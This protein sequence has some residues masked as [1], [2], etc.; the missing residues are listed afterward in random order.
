MRRLGISLGS[1][2]LIAIITGTIVDCST[3]THLRSKEALQ[4]SGNNSNSSGTI[5]LRKKR[6]IRYE[7]LPLSIRKRLA[8]NLETISDYE[9]DLDDEESDSFQSI[10]RYNRGP[11]DADNDFD[12]HSVDKRAA[13]TNEEES[14]EQGVEEIGVNDPVPNKS[15]VKRDK[16]LQEDLRKKVNLELAKSQLERVE[17]KVEDEIRSLKKRSKSSGDTSKSESDSKKRQIITPNVSSHPRLLKIE[18]DTFEI[19]QESPKDT[20][21]SVDRLKKSEIDAVS[22]KSS[23]DLQKDVRRELPLS[24]TENELRNKDKNEPKEVEDQLQRRIEAVKEKV[25]REIEENARIKE[26]EAN[27]AKYDELMRSEEKNVEDTMND[28]G[29]EKRLEEDDR[30]ESGIINGT[31]QD[32]AEVAEEDDSLHG[33][34]RKRSAAVYDDLGD[35]SEIEEEIKLRRKGN[36][37]TRK[38]R[39]SV[40]PAPRYNGL[41]DSDSDLEIEKS[42]ANRFV[43]RSKGLKEGKRRLKH[44]KFSGTRDERESFLFPGRLYTR[45][46]REMKARRR[47]IGSHKKK[48]GG[49]PRHKHRRQS[50]GLDGGE[51][52]GR[53]ERAAD[54]PLD[55]VVADSVADANSMGDLAN[56]QDLGAQ[57]APEYQEAFGGLPNQP[58]AALARY[59]RIRRS[60]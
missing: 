49:K 23:P 25:K 26:I 28:S 31:D 44:S 20:F 50:G 27:N 59:K 53:W 9:D 7:D 2:I 45:Q 18:V 6:L 16:I 56:A 40:I 37:K 19:G 57:L 48:R 35:N 10:D 39:K 58:N 36:P 54:E 15:R 1:C 4:D 34:I 12:D 8:K 17:K 41:D 60:S 5:I 11:S 32:E 13:M 22:S 29:R 30:E 21:D 55:E 43:R 33:S 42:E 24:G 51:I 47:R 14:N 46:R 52:K 38:F 3:V